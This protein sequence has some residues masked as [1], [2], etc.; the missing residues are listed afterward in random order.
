MKRFY[1]ILLTLLFSSFVF[2]Q[3]DLFTTV[4]SKNSQIKKEGTKSFVNLTVGEKLKPSDIIKCAQGGSASFLHSSGKVLVFNKSKETKLSELLSGS[5]SAGNSNIAGQLLEITNNKLNPSTKVSSNIG[6]VRATASVSKDIFFITPRRGTKVLDEYPVFNWNR[7][8]GEKEFQLT[9]LTEDLEVIKTVNL[10]DTVY[11]YSEKDPKLQKGLTYICIVKPAT[12][13]KQ[14]EYQT[15]TIAADSESVNMKNRIRETETLL[16]QADDLTKSILL[17][18]TYEALEL[19][20]DAY[21]EYVKAI[22]LSPNEKAYRKMLADL[23]VR[24]NLIKEATYLSGY[25]PADNNSK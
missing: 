14:S 19:F 8:Q 9:V 3:T 23:L 6:G 15:F 1:F 7:M 10:K 13:A 12:S 4:A 2:A 16:A 11:K 17:G 25:N 22:T 24:V 5:S 20:S 18:T 21:I